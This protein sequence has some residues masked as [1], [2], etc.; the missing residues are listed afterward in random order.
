MPRKKQRAKK[1]TNSEPTGSELVAT[2]SQLTPVEIVNKLVKGVEVQEKQEHIGQTPEEY[3][4]KATSEAGVIWK[5]ILDRIKSD[6]SF[7]ESSEESR[8]EWVQKEHKEFQ[9]EF[10]IVCRYMLCMGQYKES[11]F[12]LYLKKVKNVESTPSSISEKGEREDNW[13]KRQADYVKYLWAACNDGSLIRNLGMKEAKDVWEQTYKSLRKEFADFR[14][15]HKQAESRIEIEEKE[16]RA[17]LVQELTN[18]IRTG[19]Q[20][21]PEEDTRSLVEVLR[22]QVYQQRK[23]KMVNLFK[24]ACDQNEVKSNHRLTVQDILKP[25]KLLPS[26]EG[27]GVRIISK[28]ETELER[29]KHL[30]PMVRHLAPETSASAKFIDPVLGESKR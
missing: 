13:C 14:D 6:P 24:E 17:E 19:I 18:R 20:K 25:V 28:K 8:I 12:R 11:A 2:P 27:V 30:M 9:H 15:M 4:E 7:K 10:P 23:D 3:I 29:M 26:A 22:V 1:Q 5:K 21:L 16:N